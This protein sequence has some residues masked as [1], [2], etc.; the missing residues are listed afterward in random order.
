MMPTAW[1]IVAAADF[2]GDGSPDILFKN[3]STGEIGIWTMSGTTITGW[4]VLPPVI[5]AWEI[6]GAADFNGDGQPDILFK[7]SST[8]EIGLWKM[9]YT[10]PTPN[11][12]TVL[13]TVVP[14]WQIVNH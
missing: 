2:N 10:Q 4:I 12:W 8:G 1:K 13:P 14:A 7:N 11:G 5:P 6:V 9:T 3:S